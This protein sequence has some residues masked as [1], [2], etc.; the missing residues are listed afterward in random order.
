MNFIDASALD[1]LAD[2]YIKNNYG[3]YLK[4]LLNEQVF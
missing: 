3:Q 4:K 2:K 1:K